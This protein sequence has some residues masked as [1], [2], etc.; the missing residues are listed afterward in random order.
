MKTL[1]TISLLY[2]LTGCHP[3]E[4]ATVKINAVDASNNQPIDSINCSILENGIEII[5]T[6]TIYGQTQM[7]FDRKSNLTYELQV[8]N[9]SSKKYLLVQPSGG[10]ITLGQTN[11]FNLEFLSYGN[12]DL[13]L[14]T[15]TGTSSNDYLE[16]QL[17]NLDYYEISPISNGWNYGEKDIYGAQNN[18]H[19]ITHELPAGN[20]RLDYRVTRSGYTA[21]GTTDIAIQSGDANHFLLQY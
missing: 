7:A 18:Q 1:L 14:E 15:L 3:A 10:G 13:G 16:Y 6:Y 12:L 11:D 8:D 2:L 9:E 20:Y 17:V 19:F 4:M 5:D 21:S